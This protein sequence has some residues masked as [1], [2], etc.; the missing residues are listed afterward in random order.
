MSGRVSVT[1]ADGRK[2]AG[3]RKTLRVNRRRSLIERTHA[4]NDR[5]AKKLK[6]EW[7]VRVGFL[8][9]N[10]ILV[11][12]GNHGVGVEVLVGG[13]FCQISG[14]SADECF[15]KARNFFRTVGHNHPVRTIL[16]SIISL[17]WPDKHYGRFLTIVSIPSLI[18][19][20][21]PEP[22]VYQ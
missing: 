2:V 17:D 19:S 21:G 5:A 8:I 14:A 20:G 7:R 10:D 1:L 15:A 6:S 4:L 11:S 16:A 18:A 12:D 3:Y 13:R 9:P 22:R